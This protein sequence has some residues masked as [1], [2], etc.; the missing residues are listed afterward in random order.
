MRRESVLTVRHSGLAVQG[1]PPGSSESGPKKGPCLRGL[2]RTRPAR[3]PGNRASL[4]AGIGRVEVQPFNPTDPTSNTARPPRP[5][6][7]RPRPFFIFGSANLPVSRPP[8]LFG[9]ASVRAS[10]L[11]R[12]RQS[13]HWHLGFTPGTASFSAMQTPAVR[14]TTKA[15]KVAV[16]IPPTTE[17][18]AHAPETPSRPIGKTSHLAPGGAR[19]RPEPGL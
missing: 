8:L 16:P 4:H 19:L 11:P 9:G 1:I 2:P 12:E 13:P 15:E 18:E 7:R 17:E 14:T 5:K 10:R 3:P 6:K